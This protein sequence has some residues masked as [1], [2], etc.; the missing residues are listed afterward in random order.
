MSA[1]LGEEII[2]IS[3]SLF[4]IPILTEISPSNIFETQQDAL[5]SLAMNENSLL[6][7]LNPK[8][9][10]L[11]LGAD[12]EFLIVFQEV[13]EKL[14]ELVAELQAEDWELKVD[15]V[16][17]GG[18]VE[19]SKTIGKLT[20]NSDYIT[21]PKSDIDTI[22]DYFFS[23]FNC[24]FT[25]SLSSIYC[26]CEDPLP[27]LYLKV[28]EIQLTIP[29]SVYQDSECELKITYAN[30]SHWVL[31]RPFF[32]AYS[33]LGNL[34]LHTI[35]IYT[36]NEFIAEETEEEEEPVDDSVLSNDNLILIGEILI[37]C[38]VIFLLARMLYGYCMTIDF[39]HAEEA[40]PLLSRSTTPRISTPKGFLSPR[41]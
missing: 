8:V 20:I 18:Y 19:L 31:G 12:L 25:N 27:D 22:F 15:G 21:G 28:G 13:Y 3:G 37:G 32:K 24:G 1:Q 26:A 40:T 35:S 17:F 2:E 23:K 41:K 5:V 33:L 39:T 6:A 4:K 38:I 9:I 10:N 7:Q 34:D 11:H 36:S 16:I 14:G 30:I 29:K